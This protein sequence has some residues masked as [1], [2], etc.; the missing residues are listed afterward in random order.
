MK[1]CLID[2]HQLL[3]ELLKISLADFDFVESVNIYNQADKFFAHLDTVKPNFLILDMLMPDMN[4]IDIIRNCRKTRSKTEL[5]IL[6]L[7]SI[8]NP[9]T[10]RAA[11]KMGANGYL[12]KDASVEE[13]VEA[14][15]FINEFDRKTYVGNSLKEILVQSQLFEDTVTFTLSPREKEL[16]HYVCLGKTVK[17]IA[18]I[19][20]LSANTIQSYMRQLM[21]KM[22]VNRM[23]D[24][25]LKAIEYGLFLPNSMA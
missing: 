11:F 21:Y 25:I 16:L 4:G 22:D 12:C 8:T 5:K 9:N 1:I 19:L 17:E 20:D 18:I 3:S 7:S 2:D 14:I 24:L 6:V 15:Q 13:L 10:I 23:P